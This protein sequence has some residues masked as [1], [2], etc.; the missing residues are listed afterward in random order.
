MHIR[1]NTMHTF[2]VMHTSSAMSILFCPHN[3]A[4]IAGVEWTRILSRKRPGY[5]LTHPT[6]PWESIKRALVVPPSFPHQRPFVCGAC[7]GTA[8][9]VV[10]LVSLFDPLFKR[11]RLHCFDICLTWYLPYIKIWWQHL[12]PTYRVCTVPR[13][14]TIP[15]LTCCMSC[16]FC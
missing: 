3:I 15:T 7:I 6:P 8:Q 9:V 1:R 12:V 4:G 5:A 11:S 10:S 13:Y 2:C 16:L 14:A